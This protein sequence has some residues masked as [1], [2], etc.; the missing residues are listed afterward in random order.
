[1][2]ITKSGEKVNEE[3]CSVTGFKH[4]KNNS[5]LGDAWVLLGED[6]CFSEVKKNTYNQVRPYKYN[7]LVG[8]DTK[9]DKWCVIPPDEVITEFCFKRKGHHTTDPMEVVSLGKVK[10]KKFDNY[11]VEKKDLRSAVINAYLQ[12]ETNVLVKDYATKR[13]KEYEEAPSK[14]EEEIQLLRKK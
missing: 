9:T 14:R 5:P 13:R 10:T 6:F 4:T 7:V 1:M 11:R 12:G 3:F 2:G 8:Y